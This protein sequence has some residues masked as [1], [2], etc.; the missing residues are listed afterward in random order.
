[1]VPSV[2]T[3]LWTLLNFTSVLKNHLHYTQVTLHRQC[4]DI[5][6]AFFLEEDIFYF[7]HVNCLKELHKG[8]WAHPRPL[9]PKLWGYS[10]LNELYLPRKRLQKVSRKHSLIWQFSLNLCLSIYTFVSNTLV[11]LSV[12]KQHHFKCFHWGLCF[13]NSHKFYLI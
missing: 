9:N 13:F 3:E 5:N 8:D 11:D 1:M 10:R 7:L 6:I 2:N 12:N 4:V